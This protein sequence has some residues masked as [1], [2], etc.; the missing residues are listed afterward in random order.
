MKKAFLIP[1]AFLLL[2]YR[3]ARAQ[4]ERV[5]IGTLNPTQTLDVNGNLR[6]RPLKPPGGNQLLVAQPDGTLG[7]SQPLSA[8]AGL[9]LYTQVASTSPVTVGPVSGTAYTQVAAAG[10]YLFVAGGNQFRAYDVQAVPT[11]PAFLTN[12]TA[13]GTIGALAVSGSA[14]YAVNSTELEIFSLSSSSPLSLS[15]QRSVPLTPPGTTSTTIYDAV[16]AGGYLYVAASF[17]GS[18]YGTA[19]VVRVFDLTN[20]LQPVAAATLPLGLTGR[21]QLATDESRGRLLVVPDAG[22]LQVYALATPTAPT[23]VLIATAPATA[24]RL[25][26]FEGGV[27]V[28]G[29]ILYGVNNATTPPTLDVYDEASPADPSQ[30]AALG[31]V[32]L[33]KKVRGLAV[34]GEYAYLLTADASSYELVAVRVAAPALVG[35]DAAGNVASV[36]PVLPPTDNLGNHRATQ[37]LNLAGFQLVGNG[38]SQG[39]RLDA[40]G[41]VGVL[42]A[43]SNSFRLDVGGALRTT[44][45]AVT[46]TLA[47]PT[48]TASTSLSTPSLLAPVTGAHPC[49]AAA[50]GQVIVSGNNTASSGSDNYSVARTGTGTYRLTFTAGPLA[51][52]NLQAAAFLAALV[53]TPGFVTFTA[54]T[55]NPYIDV[56][57]RNP[58]GTLTDRDFTFSVFLP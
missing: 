11:V 39:L 21:V 2:G 56:Y 3:P 15:R 49:L 30:P 41:R 35:L 28:V 58:N 12:T 40:S 38:G 4:Q 7:L 46:G 8:T 45:M 54:S 37:N 52:G 55:T 33:P 48:L 20:P 27:A 19:A 26:T 23:P 17:S 13:S 44:N 24:P 10:R 57:T 22:S 29:G 5:G 50:T 9:G 32:R 42:T 36:A 43:P 31:A 14:V 47:T 34:A 51:T 53:G 25:P 6:V 18:S 16:L 1:L